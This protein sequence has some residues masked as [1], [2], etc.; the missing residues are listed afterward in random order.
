MMGRGAPPFAERRYFPFPLAA[1]PPAPFVTPFALPPAGDVV[2]VVSVGVFPLVELVVPAFAPL[3]L[4]FVPEFPPV[5]P[6]LECVGD[7]VVVDFWLAVEVLL[8][9]LPW[10]ERVVLVGGPVTR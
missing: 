6:P 10:C 4:T 9:C 3:W 7:G 5:L 1:P 2:P 8:T